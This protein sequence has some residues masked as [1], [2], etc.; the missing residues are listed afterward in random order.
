MSQTCTFQRDAIGPSVLGPSQKESAGTVTIE[1]YDGHPIMVAVDYRPKDQVWLVVAGPRIYMEE[2]EEHIR[3][4]P[5]KPMTLAEI[6]P[7][8]VRLPL[9]V[10]PNTDGMKEL[11]Q[12]VVLQVMTD[13]ELNLENAGGIANG[14]LGFK[15]RQRIYCTVKH[16]GRSWIAECR[17]HVFGAEVI[18]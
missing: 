11:L 1:I 16:T 10:L 13:K 3:K 6:E 4:G 12:A 8:P 18:Q 2:E 15:G 5:I 7:E 9:V 17:P 14:G